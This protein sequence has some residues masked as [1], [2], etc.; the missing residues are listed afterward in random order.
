MV[1]NPNYEWIL[2]IL[3]LCLAAVILILELV[4]RG[5]V[6]FF[7]NVMPFLPNLREFLLKLQSYLPFN[8]SHF[9]AEDLNEMDMTTT[10][11]IEAIGYIAEAHYVYSEDGYLLCLHRIVGK[12][13]VTESSVKKMPILFMHGMIMSSE[14]WVARKLAENNL[15]FVLSDAGYDV[16]LGNN[17]GNKYSCKHKKYKLL[18]EQF[19]NF[20]ID[21]LAKY[22]LPAFAD[23]IILHTGYDKLG[24][25]GFSQGSTQ[26]LAA[27]SSNAILTS[28]IALF[29][30]LAPTALIEG[31][32]S[33]TA[34]AIATTRL[35]FLYQLFGKKKI[36]SSNT[37]LAIS[38]D[39][40]TFCSND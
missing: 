3:R 33:K 28:K 18:D 8:D 19:W 20:S 29:V 24:Y 37:I 32:Y 40:N 35:P 39:T 4:I 22:D 2:W 1:I 25:I 16:W 5:V 17:R 34:T 12:I 11:L 30:G 10:E 31:L 26:A 36:F 15:P 14:V 9:T 7:W 21:D 38:N 23:Y 6:S 13:P 27:F